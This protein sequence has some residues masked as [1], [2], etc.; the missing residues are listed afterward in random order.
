MGEDLLDFEARFLVRSRGC[1]GAIDLASA[2][3]NAAVFI[4]NLPIADVGEASERQ[5][6]VST[7]IRTGDRYS[8]LADLGV[9]SGAVE[10]AREAWLCAMTAFEVAKRIVDPCNPD[11]LHIVAKMQACVHKFGLYHAR[12]IERVRIACCDQPELVTY[13]LPHDSPERHAPSIIC[14]SNQGESISEFLGKV[15]PA[16][17][18]RG[19]SLLVVDGSELSDHPTFKSDILLGC[20]VDYLSDRSDVDRCRIGVYGEGMA[21]VEATSLA[22][23]D[24]RIAA[25]VCDGGLWQF[26]WTRSSIDCMSGLAGELCDEEASSARRMRLVRRMRCPVLVVSGP[27]ESV[28]LS[29]AISLQADCKAAG[30]DMSVVV[31]RT[32]ETPLGGIEN[33]LTAD[34][35]IFGWLERKLKACRPSLSLRYL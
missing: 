2:R 1:E 30:I 24:R 22:S 4:D 7:W 9:R 21:A 10:R 18:G 13:Y 5:R 11:H 15:L 27:R 26:A 34:E 8:S 25:A 29:E 12:S 20:C 17:V 32:V 33:F 28:D 3:R 14:I 35:F 23:S 31:S 6:W 16:A 19:M